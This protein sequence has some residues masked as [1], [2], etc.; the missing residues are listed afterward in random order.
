MP[1]RFKIVFEKLAEFENA[2]PEGCDATPSDVE[3]LAQELDE[4]A[5]LRRIVTD[6]SEPPSTTFTST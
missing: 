6:V 5:E 4:I 3:A 1:D 2:R